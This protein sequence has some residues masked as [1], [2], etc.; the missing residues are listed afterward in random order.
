MPRPKT[1]DR[2]E[3]LDRA[4]EVFWTRGYEGASIQHLVDSMGINRG[5]IYDTFGDKHQ[6]F[7]EALDRYEVV[8]HTRLLEALDSA[9]SPRRAIQ[10][11]FDTVIQECACDERRKGCFLTNSAVELSGH[12]HDTEAR[13]QENF[14]RLEE[15]FEKAL[16]A[17]IE[18]EEISERH[19]PRALARFLTSS[20]QGLRVMSKTKPNRLVLRDIVK[21][22]LSSLD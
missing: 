8:F 22:T 2:E 4:I 17:G 16:C 11:V 18:K 13:V 12:D 21:V 1:F 5:S 9:Q 7:L 6:L 14:H 20:L 15:A 19:H 3:V 10:K